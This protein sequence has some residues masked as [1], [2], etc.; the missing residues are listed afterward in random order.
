MNPVSETRIQAAEDFGLRNADQI[1]LACREAG[2]PFFVACA[3]F[4]KE[5]GGRNLWGNDVGG[6]FADLPNDWLVTKGAFEI[7]EFYVVTKQQTSNGVG[8]AQITWRGFFPDMRAKGLKPWVP[9]DNMLYGLQ[10]IHDYKNVKGA[11]WEDAGTK[12]NGARSYGE[13]FAEKVAEWKNR[14]AV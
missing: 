2:V 6:M 9:H 4:E 13:D 12:Y 5:S 8:P 10:L 14:L 7:F 11:T 1:A 3:L